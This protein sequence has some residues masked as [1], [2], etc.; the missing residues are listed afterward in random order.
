MQ[1]NGLLLCL[2]LH[3]TCLVSALQRTDL[4]PFGPHTG[5]VALQEGDDVTSEAIQL[6]RPL[7]F[8]DTQF[9]SLYVGTNGIISLQ[10]LPRESQYVDDGFPIDFPVIAPYLS[11][12]DTSQGRGRI[13]YREDHSPDT[14]ERVGWELRKAFPGRGI[15]P[16]NSF[17]ATWENV[18]PYEEMTRSN[19]SSNRFNTFQ[20]V[21]VFDE[22]DAYAI[23]LYPEDGL[24]FFGTRPKDSYNVQFELPARVGFSRGET[25]FTRWRGE[26]SYYSVTTNEQSVKNL[27]QMGNSG[28]PGIW[29]FH[30]GGASS[31]N[32]IMQAD[33]RGQPSAEDTVVTLDSALSGPATPDAR[34]P[35]YTANEDYKYYYEGEDFGYASS[36]STPPPG[37]DGGIP[38]DPPY[39]DAG[40]IPSYPAGYPETGIMSSYPESGVL[41]SY[42]ERD[43][44]VGTGV[45]YPDGY[46][47]VE[48]LPGNPQ[49]VTQDRHVVSV[50]EDGNLGT[51]VFTYNTD[52]RETCAR[53]R[54]QCSQHAYC[55]DY[56]SGLCC[57]CHPGY[58]GNGRQCLQE[59]VTQRVNGKV[60][61]KLMVGSSRVPVEFKNAD[62]HAYVVVNDGRAFTAISQIPESVG[63]A[64]QS[65]SVIGDLF[66]WLFAVQ[67]PGFANGFSIAGAKFIRSIDITFYPGNEQL[68]IMQIA[69]GLDAHNYLSVTTEI[70]G[71][72]PDISAGAT[73]QIQP[74][75]ELLYRSTSA[76]TSTAHRDYSVEAGNG[77]KQT[78]RYQLRQNITY[79]DCEHAPKTIPDAQQLNADHIFVLYDRD[80]Q[81]IRYAT[82]NRIGPARGNPRPDSVNP[83]QDGSHNCDPKAQCY[84]LNDHEHICTCAPGYEGDGKVCKDIDECAGGSSHGCGANTE[85]VNVPGSYGCECKQGYAVPEGGNTCVPTTAASERQKSACEQQRDRLEAEVRLRGSQPLVGHHIPQCDE[86]GNFRP[87]QC[88]SSTGHCW[89]VYENGQEVPG[90]RTLP[91]TAQPRCGTTG[92]SERPKTAC[93]QQRDRLEAEVR[94]RGSQPLVGHHIPQCD[95]E[96]NFRPMQC[97]S[98]TG[99]CWCVYENGQEV[100]GSRTPPGTA[101][102]RCGTTGDSEQPKSACEQQRDRLE[103]EVRLRGSQPLLGHH[104]PQCDE[105]GNFRPMQCQSSTGHCW[106]VYENG[107]EV[108]GSRTL[109][110]TAQ[111]RCGTTGDSEQPKSACEQ[112]R[113]RLEA[114]VRL[115]GSQPLLGHHIPQCDE[116]GNFRPMQCQSST[117]H[118]WCV[119]ENGQ[120][121]LGSRTPP[122]TAQPRCGTTGNS[123]RPKS[124]CEQQRDRLEAE[125]RLRGSQPLLG[126]HI[127]QC[128]EEGNFRPV[129][130]QSSTGHCWCVY[131][132]GQEIPGSRT[133]PGAAQPRCG[134]T[135]TVEASDR[136]KTACEQQ[137]DRL[138]AEVRLRGS[139]P[140]VGQHI[141][142]CDEEGN[143]RPMQCHSSTGHCW[144]VYENG[145]EVLWSRTLPGTAQPRCGTTATTAVSERPKSACEQQRDRLEAEVRQHG[146][147]PML[148][149]YI[150]Q[151]D[152]EGNFRLMQ[153]HSSTGHCWC[154]HENGQEVPGT[155]APPG[156]SQPHCGTTAAIDRPKSAC[157]QHR[158][159]MEAEVSLRG[160]LVG[161]HIPQCDEEGNFRPMQCQSSTGHCWCVY[162]NG[163]EVLGTRTPPGTTQPRCGTTEASDRPKS[164][165]EQQ[166][167]RL[168]A[169]VRLRGSQPLLGHHIP[170][171]DEEGN[172]RPMQCQSSTG[173]CWCVH[174]NGQEVLGSRTPPGTAQPRCGT[175]EASARPKSACEQQRDRLEAEVRLR[176][177]QPLVGHHI[178]QCDEEGNFRPLQCHSSTGH[179]WCVYENGQEVPGTRAPPGTAQPRCGTT[180]ANVLVKSACEQH[181]E[182]MEAEVS[183]RGPLVGLHI[184]QCDEEGNFRPMQCQS[185]TGHCWCVYENGQEVQGTRTEAG[186][187]QPRCGLTE[188]NEHPTTA[189]E[190][191][192]QRLQAIMSLRGPLVGLHIPQCDEE[193]NFRPMQ[194]HSSTGHCWCVHENGQE[195][196]G[197]RT[198]PGTGQPRCG[199]T[200]A[201]E[202]PKSACEQQRYRLE[203]EVRLRGSQPLVGHHIP[204]CD[205]EGNFRPMQCHSST[206]HCWCVYENGQEVPGSRT[207]PGTAQPRCGTTAADEQPKSACEQHRE[208]MEAEVSLRGPIVGL[209]IPQCD[210]EGNFR[211]MQCQS[212]TGH[213][214]CVYENGQEVQGTRTPPGTTQPRCGPTVSE[215]NERPKTACEEQQQRL[216]MEMRAYGPEPL[217][218]HH[219]PQC[220]EE[221]NFRLMQCHSSTGHCWCVYENGQEVPNTR[222]PPGTAQPHCDLSATNE[223]PQTDCEE[224]RE[225]LQAEMSRHGSQR[226]GLHIPQCDEAGRFRTI[227]CHGSTGHC[228]CVNENGREIP[229]TRTPPGT[230]QIRCGSAEQI[231]QP[232][233]ACARHHEQVQR[234]LSEHGSDPPVGVY[235]PQCDEEGNYQE[236]QCHSS[237]G[238]CWCVD[239][240]GLEVP[241]TSRGP[242]RGLPR[243]GQTAPMEAPKAPC[244]EQR[245]QL[246][247]ELSIH[248][249]R[250][251]VG[252]YVP[253]CDALG[254]FKPLQCHDST[255]QCWC[256]DELGREI[257][258]T[259]TL[260]GSDQPRCGLPE[261]LQRPQTVCERWRSSLLEHYGGSPADD[262]YVPRCTEFGE[263]SPLQCHGNSGYCWCVDQEGREMPGT[264]TEPGTPPACIPTVPPPVTQPTTASVVT[265]PP[266]GAFLLYAQ[267]QHI[268]YLPLNGTRLNKD[269]ARSLLALHG[270]IIIGIDYDC[271]D[272]MVYWTDVAGRT[273]NRVSLEA[274]AEPEMIIDMGLTSPEGLTLDYHHRRMFWTDSGSDKIETAAFD[275]SERRVLVD[276][277]LVNP[278]AIVV[279]SAHGNLYW[280]DWN[281][282]APKIE[283]SRVDGTNRR[284]LINKDIGLPNGLTFDRYFSQLC[285]AD[286]GTKNLECVNPDG[287]GRRVIQSGLNYPFSI[288]AYSNHF[289]YTDWKRDG[290]I[291]LPKVGRQNQYGNQILDEYLPD[292]RS[293]LYGIT[294]AY[295]SCPYGRK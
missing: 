278:R 207:L 158:E 7:A 234:E 205:E 273:I 169:E 67:Q 252:V 86:E 11:D 218:G 263:F 91:G 38:D 113:D 241:G 114:E 77:E 194:C 221:G 275:G 106:C 187:A 137:R 98:S 196:Q 69:R 235:I 171:C 165:C 179:C 41:S 15:N 4:F 34:E 240:E 193:G 45:R 131:E 281:R 130:C 216:Q 211:P 63:W 155:R 264:R 256:V 133:P 139:Q 195:V 249:A 96:G 93:E 189:C 153:C 40:I 248:R 28:S 21:L 183:L 31:F 109:P 227:Q 208:R 170:Q 268:G 224:Q 284:I 52:T 20:A 201:S 287:S 124:A 95:E 280:T 289:Y 172:F 269:E 156:T 118:C 255:S 258:G 135:V 282:E 30:I 141:P 132:S 115:R 247:E 54:Q 178:P 92:D 295:P 236:M 188:T 150:P 87:M 180:A 110:G 89:C 138:E 46:S 84:A 191:Q 242:G 164:A 143:F 61:G 202:Q 57:H 181:Q 10:E 97:Q 274:G 65:L 22:S 250:P 85:C 112:Q 14:L 198:E 225:R 53:S 219:I 231:E 27:Y 90:S 214:W 163:Q 121:V 82:I 16:G 262:Q 25:E 212:S 58:Y 243:C 120:E 75:E 144:C 291:V 257:P 78:H 103:A 142:Q 71:E 290:I 151:C 266:A 157:E 292:Q 166:R 70:E 8:Y 244:A 288:V 26:G 42:P 210:E 272:K 271:R 117:G 233:N 108:P 37:R 129:Q 237:T 186:T 136:Q 293:H 105:E 101:Q 119:Y 44:E 200:G 173:H 51:G 33:V 192:R 88:H 2:L 254:N 215:S 39:P 140:L 123:E 246:Q 9:N 260:P 213:C 126:H 184:P 177:S 148:G 168:E 149:L 13:Y 185:S 19:P 72:L 1:R 99:H 32:N 197:T 80:E 206:G 232:K 49:P 60:N 270:S 261:P 277:D 229:G 47:E 245:D 125:V 94:L 56:S 190:Q 76:V 100:L 18:A 122:G 283:T 220:D 36:I 265:V 175:T 107:Q 55:A 50:V 43:P 23:F 12:I 294:V 228:W 79:Y 74:Y 253:Q 161:F 160:P 48:S 162:E 174:E 182:R 104:I 3:W 59:G 146:S 203:A 66:G 116:E 81:V 35:D 226:L 285:W 217:L 204:Q 128:D 238:Y 64:M 154:V 127:P 17:I 24:N 152:E 62:L 267:G 73:I 147:Q 286:A 222:T 259:R 111:P 239:V 209:H 276:T 102:P 230:G 167:D 29:I 6:R 5:D 279:D 134:V 159:R 251:A 199:T 83:C 68:N 176:G 145:Q 223:R